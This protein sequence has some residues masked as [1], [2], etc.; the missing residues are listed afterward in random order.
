MLM[1]ILLQNTAVTHTSLTVF[2]S[3]KVIKERHKLREL[4]MV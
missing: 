4:E 3:P 1:N 2:S